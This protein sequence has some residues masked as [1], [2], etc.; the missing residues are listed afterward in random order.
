[1]VKYVQL[2]NDIEISALFAINFVLL[3]WDMSG[4]N[5]EFGIP[6]STPLLKENAIIDNIK[7]I[8]K[9]T[10]SVVIPIFIFSNDS[11]DEIK[12]RLKEENI[13]E[14]DNDAVFPIFIKSK[15]D[16]FDESGQCIMFDLINTWLN[17]IPSIYVTQKW[18]NTYL[19]AINGKIGRAHV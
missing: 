14:D 4:L 15:S 7:F 1:M 12:N 5:D 19:E 17:T 10:Q 18:K 13:L 3:D 2:P 11:V 8:K 6:I 9:I 16:L